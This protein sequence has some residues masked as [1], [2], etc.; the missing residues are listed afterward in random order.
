MATE[1]IEPP[2]SIE[3]FL[4]AIREEID[5]AVDF[6]TEEFNDDFEKADRYYNGEVDLPAEQG[7]SQAVSTQVR[8]TIRSMLPSIMRVL[9]SN[10]KRLVDYTPTSVRFGPIVDQQRVYIHSLFWANDGY[11]VLFNAINETLLHK[12]GPVKVYWESSPTPEYAKIT[13]LT[14]DEVQFIEEA[15]GIEVLSV[16][17]SFPIGR[18]SAADKIAIENAD[19]LE[20]YDVEVER[21]AGNGRI[22]IEAVQYGEFFISRNATTHRNAFVHGHR[23]SVTVAEAMDMGLEHDDW[24][25]LDDEDPQQAR[26]S[27]QSEAQRGYRKEEEDGRG[28]VMSHKFLLTECYCQLDLE[29][30]GY[31]QLYCLKLG[32]TNYELLAY[33]REGDSAFEIARHDPVPFSVIGRSIADIMCEQQD[34]VT[35]LLRGIL[36]NVHMA[37][38]PRL[39]GNPQQVNFDDLMSWDIGH[40]IRFKG[41]GTAVQSIAVPSQLQGT[42]PMLQYLETDSQNKV[43]VT[44]AAQ[45]LDPDA[46]QS[47]DKEAVRNT[48]QL[49]QGQVEL[50]VRNI[51][52][53]LV[54][55]LFKKLLKL[56]IQHLDRVQIIKMRGSLVAVDQMLF[57]ADWQAEPAVGLGA[58]DEQKR[59]A[60]LNATLQAQMTAYDKFGANN[61]FV[62]LHHIYNTLED[63]TEMYGLHDVS[64]YFNI[65]DPA[66]EAKFAEEQAKRQAEMEAAKKG[67]QLDPA[68]ALVQTEQIKAQTEK[69]KT[70]TKARTDALQLQLKAYE[71][72][73]KDDLERDKM[74]Q[75]REMETTKLF[76]Q[77]GVQ[78]DS[79]AIKRD[80][81]ANRSNEA[82][83]TLAQNVPTGRESGPYAEAAE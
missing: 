82:Q 36:D 17:K 70:I 68:V 56:S 71:L 46:M 48:I 31:N 49:S 62:S 7:R 79:N 72:D 23:R 81:E 39:G 32:G 9:L 4:P 25:S 24:F 54:I 14:L 8:D 63:I 50:A 74:A 27:G 38:N 45:G 26:V 55:P 44:K 13:G 11:M 5:A 80:Q 41:T 61:P 21:K 18:E 37:N 60:G 43:G 10:R 3:D 73:S 40:P 19:M 53:T 33:E 58:A 20:L 69:L 67:Q 59:M 15:E 16:E 78:V 75:Q 2:Y 65:V 66:V 12:F 35:S 47:T 83:Q 42:L 1:K 77:L 64:R 29:D 76:G 30:T 51:I 34:V 6:I 57:D 52:E 22:V 28:D